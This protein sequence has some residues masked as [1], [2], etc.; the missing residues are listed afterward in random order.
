MMEEP[1][2]RTLDSFSPPAWLQ[3]CFVSVV[4]KPW[5]PPLI[6]MMPLSDWPVYSA[7]AGNGSGRSTVQHEPVLPAVHSGRRLTRARSL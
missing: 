3:L 4:R 1:E 7:H 5:A 2:D 6:R